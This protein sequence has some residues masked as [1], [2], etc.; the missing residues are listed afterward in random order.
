MDTDSHLSLTA[1][2][3]ERLLTAFDELDS[4]RILLTGGTGFVGKW[5]LQTAKIAQENSQT[6]VEIVVPSRRLSA[7]HAQAAIAIGC[8]NVS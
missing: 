1:P 2:H 4:S 3:L 7:H 6:K 8:P 5:M